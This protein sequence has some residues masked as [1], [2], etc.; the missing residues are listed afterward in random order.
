MKK[1]MI[2]SAIAM[3]MTAGSAM[4]AVQQG[5]QGEVQFIG[6]V[7]A[8]TCDVIVSGDGA[9]SN[10]VKFGVVNTSETADKDFKISL[11]DPSCISGATKATFVWSS[12]VLSDT[13]IKNQSGT[14]TEAYVE[15]KPKSG[16]SNAPTRNDAVTAQN[17]SVEFAVSQAEMGFDYQ[18]TLH[19]ESVPGD[20]VTAAAYTV[21]Y[22]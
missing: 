13:G 2:A 21:V 22:E 6:T 11:K 7:A 14:A 17:N 20:F 3:V 12:P 15:L 5:S 16:G 18:A 4:A 10:Q 1:L 8:K 19:A 9:T